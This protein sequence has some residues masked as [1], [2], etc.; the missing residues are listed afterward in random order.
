MVLFYKTTETFQQGTKTLPARYYTSELVFA[1]ETERIFSDR[2]FCVGRA[3]EIP[4]PGDYVL[5]QVGHENLIVVRDRHGEVQAFYNLCRHRG[6]RLCTESQGHFSG[7]IRCPYH[8]WGYALSGQL[9]AAPLMQEVQGFDP[10]DYALAPVAIAQ[11]EGL[12]FVHL[13]T[14][15]QPFAEAFAPVIDRF[16]Q[17]QIPTLRQGYRIE[18]VLQANWKIIIQNYSECYHCPTVHPAL[19]K[20]SP[21]ISSA[22]DLY[23]G[24]FIGGP[25]AIAPAYT[26]L[27]TGGD[28]TLPVVGQVSGENLQR[29]YYYL[30]FPNLLL[31]LQPDFVMLHRLEPQ[32]HNQ[33][34]IICEWLFNSTAVAH[35]DFDPSHVVSFWDTVNRE[36]WQLCES[37]QL[38]ISSR[39]YQPGHYSASESLLPEIDREVLRSLG[40]LQEK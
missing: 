32:A 39:A 27:S 30:I 26:S 35:P 6:T 24:A 14:H 16:S 37:M 1:E 19:A 21:A 10:Q 17:W 9:V 18:Y 34:T 4:N 8:A 36:D 2:W 22:N 40:H 38:G 28:R 23:Q 3:D 15:P 12:L 25:M 33:T 5:R 29:A 31:S 7:T 11:W 13:G 20:M